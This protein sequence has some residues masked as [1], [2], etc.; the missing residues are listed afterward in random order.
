MRQRRRA[1]PARNGSTR[2]VAS[3]GDGDDRGIQAISSGVGRLERD[4]DR[5]DRKLDSFLTQHQTK[6]DAEQT[7]YTTHLLA[8]AESM[9][10]SSRH[11]GLLTTLDARL[12]AIETW[13]HEL[14][15]AM[16]LVKLAMGTS[17]ISALA[18]IITLVGLITGWVH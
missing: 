9:S 17:V 15:G 14:L 11:E 13:R 3:S 1:S 4:I 8:A 5:L 18:A 6:H 7:S 10:R 12:E 16:R 2:L